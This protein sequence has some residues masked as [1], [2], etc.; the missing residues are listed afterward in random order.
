MALPLRI[1]RQSSPSQETPSVG[2][3][4]EYRSPSGQY[5]SQASPI[6]LDRVD[7]ELLARTETAVDPQVQSGVNEHRPFVWFV[8]AQRAW[9][10]SR[11]IDGL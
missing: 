8:R 4:H 7:V 6:V 3:C 2:S 5:F 1:Q 10:P 9:A 11:H